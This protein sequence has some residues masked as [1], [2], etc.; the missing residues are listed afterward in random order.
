MK[1]FNSIKKLQ[2]YLNEKTKT[3][4]FIE[5]GKLINIEITFDLT[6]DENILAR[7]INAEDINAEDI[8]A[9]NINAGN[10]NAGNITAGDIDAWNI[11]AWSMDASV[12]SFHAVCFA[13]KNIVCKSIKSRRNNTRYFSLDGEVIIYGGQ[14]NENDEKTKNLQTK[15]KE[16]QTL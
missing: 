4:E 7:D 3:Y 15:V 14:V 13:Y 6:I 8:N 10:I 16:S 9:G 11:A 5:E 12:I 1:Q 2:P